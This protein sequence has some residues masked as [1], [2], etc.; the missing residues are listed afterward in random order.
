MPIGEEEKYIQL[1]D[2]G[3]ES[4]EDIY[5]KNKSKNKINVKNKLKAILFVS[6]FVNK[7]VNYRKC[8]NYEF[9]RGYSEVDEEY[10]KNCIDE[11][12][13]VDSEGYI[14]DEKLYNKYISNILYYDNLYLEEIEK[15]MIGLKFMSIN[16]SVNLVKEKFKPDLNIISFYDKV[17]YLDHK[18][19]V[20]SFPINIKHY[21]HIYDKHILYYKHVVNSDLKRKNIEPYKAYIC[22]IVNDKRIY[23]TVSF[24]QIFKILNLF[25]NKYSIIK[26]I[27][28]ITYNQFDIT[29]LLN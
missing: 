5:I 23:E 11:I 19:Q 9:C 26:H 14:Q 29:N 17:N 6:Y 10:C 4:G 18:V 1:Y 12:Q 7:Y 2:S 15:K 20:W 27:Y 16:D 28:D 21:K 22:C 25:Y 13:T 24:I 8:T 3:Y